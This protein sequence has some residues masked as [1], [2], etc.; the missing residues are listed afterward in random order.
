ML[1]SN[2]AFSAIK[3]IPQKTIADGTAKPCL[4]GYIALKEKAS[5]L[6]YQGAKRTTS[7]LD[8]PANS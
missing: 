3:G 5:L 2:L 4:K 1:Y 7:K 8:A 6:L